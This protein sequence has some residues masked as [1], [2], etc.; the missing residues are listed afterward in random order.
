[1]L[2][3]RIT[4][5]PYKI[6]STWH[7]NSED[8]F[9]AVQSS[10]N[11]PF[12]YYCHIWIHLLPSLTMYHHLFWKIYWHYWSQSTCEELSYSCVPY[13]VLWEAI[14]QF[15]FIDY[16]VD[17]SLFVF[18]CTFSVHFL[19]MT[20]DKSICD[21]YLCLLLAIWLNRDHHRLT[22]WWHLVGWLWWLLPAASA[23]YQ[24]GT[25]Q[26]WSFWINSKVNLS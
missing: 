9:P 18:R 7:R 23:S 21:Q 5:I 19:E 24:C 12:R 8:D 2:I 16:T 26:Y 4:C 15:H 3:N 22:F 14:A 10:L 17:L 13:Y 20:E 11:P 6:M 1:M 25:W